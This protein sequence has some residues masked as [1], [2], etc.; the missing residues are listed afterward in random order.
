MTDTQTNATG[1]P[2]Y[3]AG[4][5]TIDPAHSD[6]SF[7]VRHMMVSKVRGHFETFEGQIVTGERVEDSTVTATVDLGSINTNHGQRDE[8]L[9]GSDIFDVDNHVKMTYRSTGVRQDGDDYVLDGE[10]TIRDITKSIPLTLEVNGFGPDAWGGYRSGFSAKGEISR[11]DFGIDFN[12]PLEG[13]GVV[14]GDK[15]SI[16]IE[17]EA[18]LDK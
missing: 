11:A 10:L 2:G 16:A 1:I 12:I 7:T 18:I 17:A 15:I 6:V 5:W 4:S 14:I 13:G 8:H 3:V 9:R